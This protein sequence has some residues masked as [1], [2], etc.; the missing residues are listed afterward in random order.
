MSDATDMTGL[1]QYVVV[2]VIVEP[3][4]SLWPHH[5]LLLLLLSLCVSLCVSVCLHRFPDL[6]TLD[7]SRNELQACS[8][9][10]THTPRCLQRL[11]LADNQLSFALPLRDFRH[12]LDLDLSNNRFSGA[13]HVPRLPQL[14]SLR[15]RGNLVHALQGLPALAHLDSLDVTGTLVADLQPLLTSAS[16][17]LRKLHAADT[18]AAACRRYRYVALWLAPQLTLLDDAVV[19]ESVVA[20]KQFCAAHSAA[21]ARTYRKACP[22]HSVPL[23][24]LRPASA[25]SLSVGGRR[26]NTT[27]GAGSGSGSAG[28]ASGPGTSC[29]PLREFDVLSL[30]RPHVARMRPGE[31]SSLDGDVSAEFLEELDAKDRLNKLKMLARRCAD[32]VQQRQHRA[33]RAA[34]RCS[35]AVVERLCRCTAC[36]VARG[37]MDAVTLEWLDDASNTAGCRRGDNSSGSKLPARPSSVSAASTSHR[38][39]TRAGDADVAAAALKPPRPARRVQSASLTRPSRRTRTSGGPKLPTSAS[40]SPATIA[41]T[42]PSSAPSPSSSSSSSS[43]SVAGSA[44]C[45]PTPVQRTLELG[46]GPVVMSP[47]TAVPLPAAG[48]DPAPALLT[49]LMCRPAT[50]MAVVGQAPTRRESSSSMSSCSMPPS[51]SSAASDAVPLAPRAAVPRPSTS[52]GTQ[53]RTAPRASA[54]WWG[55][56]PPG[57]RHPPL[58]GRSGSLS[59]AGA[60][61]GSLRRGSH[62][63]Q[64]ALARSRSTT[65]LPHSATAATAATATVAASSP[66]TTAWSHRVTYGQGNGQGN[67]QGSGQ[68]KGH[69]RQASAGH[70]R[71]HHR[72]H[73]QPSRVRVHPS[74]GAASTTGSTLPKPS[75]LQ[76]MTQKSWQQLALPMSSPTPTQH[77]L[78]RHRRRSPGLRGGAGGF[79]KQAGKHRA[80]FQGLASA[81]ERR[82]A[83]VL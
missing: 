20:L 28:P 34:R 25:G 10:V 3:T 41:P 61:G 56:T 53:R 74:S 33:R 60:A 76:P 79:G 54:G 50:D 15:L 75:V 6:R 5:T 46:L 4:A 51:P 22:A 18:P 82:P 63:E 71:R 26:A 42:I 78:A 17:T 12:L 58:R 70:R 35:A 2:V 52:C 16:T 65:S 83:A 67:E 23:P 1:A 32:V 29:N 47:V 39:A 48:A 66:V 24:Q 68:G 27:F 40:P 13:F 62:C 8:S 43:S 77:S 59:L 72:R 9:V 36:A 69:R 37:D 64:G 80:H 38:N 55:H 14:R 19:P 45:S 21:L 31:K 49:P 57:H 81:L 44:P 7:L 30:P 73:A 11:N